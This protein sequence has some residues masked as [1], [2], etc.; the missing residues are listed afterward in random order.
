MSSKA[1]RYYLSY[2]EDY[3]SDQLSHLP[4]KG[5]EQGVAEGFNGEY[6]DEAGM[7]SSNLHTLK[8]SVDGL[9]DTINQNDNLPEWC[10]EKIAKAEMMVTGVWDYMLS[11]KEQG[12]DPKINE[13]KKGVRA[14]KY[15]AKPRNFVAKNAT[16]SGAGAHKDKKKAE[17]QGDVKHKNKAL[18][19]A[20]GYENRL[21]AMLEYKIRK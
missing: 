19:T 5:R 1:I 6:D 10:Q 9:M 21:Q 11:Q 3:I 15:T 20:E 13:H 2:D 16:S 8:R 4:K 17:K 7:A 18:D 14:M 12:I